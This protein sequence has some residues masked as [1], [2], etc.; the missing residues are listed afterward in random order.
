MP[1]RRALPYALLPF[2]TGALMALSTGPASAIPLFSD[3]YAVTCQKCHSIVP[4]LNTF[5]TEFMANGYRIRG[6]VPG[7]AFPIAARVNLVDSSAYQ[8]DGPDG[9]G[10]PKAIVDE[11]EL[12]TAG[13]A[14]SRTNY[15][16]EQYVVDG[17]EHGSLRDAWVGQ[18][19]NPWDA[20]IPVSIQAGQFTLPVPVDP[21]TFRES[22]QHYALYDQTVGN[23][24]FNFF[25]DKDGGKVTVGDVLH[26]ASV[27]FFAGPGHDAGSGLPTVGTDTMTYAQQVLGPFTLSGYHYE[28]QRP[29]GPDLLDRFDRTGFAIVF[30]EG[31]WTSEST[32]QTGW[33]SSCYPRVGCASS[34]GFSQLRY[35]VSPRFYALARYEGISDTTGVFTRDGVL[36]LGYRPSHNS[37]FTIEDVVEHVP[38][39]TNTMNAQLTIGI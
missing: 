38:Q 9:Q 14:G 34:G 36:L 19:V 37:G 24:P 18:R 7:P 12:F 32:L 13:L 27:Q 3:Q 11:V 25:D 35:A 28:G 39:T 2:V 26:G 5:G 33:D 4:R 15:F 21:E 8:G 22:Y 1:R 29:S 6:V 17:G 31:R 23:N 10:L 20:R 30:N 16:V